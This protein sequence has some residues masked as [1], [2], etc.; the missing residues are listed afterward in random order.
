MNGAAWTRSSTALLRRGPS[1]R[2]RSYLAQISAK[3]RKLF[4][5]DHVH[6][7][8]P[9]GS[10]PRHHGKARRLVCTTPPPPMPRHHADMQTKV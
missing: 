4:L 2:A 6:G 5:S 8:D 10:A 9:N 1:R 7:F 3:F